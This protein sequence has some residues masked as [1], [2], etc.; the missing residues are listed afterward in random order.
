MHVYL[1]FVF[2]IMAMIELIT[3]YQE[4]YYT[5]PL[6]Y[7]L[8]NNKLISSTTYVTY[9]ADDSVNLYLDFKKI[10]QFSFTNK[11]DG[12]SIELFDENANNCNAYRLNSE[13]NKTL[14]ISNSIMN[15]NS[16][17]IPCGKYPSMFIGTKI[18]LVTDNGTYLPLN[19]NGTSVFDYNARDI[20]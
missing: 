10:T 2:L 17:S 3:N 5:L 4:F 13:T 6:N 15:P 9:I 18:N 14:S 1:G 16:F 19:F 11:F 7:D 20:R 12:E 8:I